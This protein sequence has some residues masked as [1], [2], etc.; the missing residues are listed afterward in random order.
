MP[1]YNITMLLSNAFRPDPRVEREAFALVHAGYQVS[2][3]AWDRQAE[4]PHKEI[5]DG[6]SID[7][8]Q[9]IR[10]GYGSGPRQIF[11]LP[12][13]WDK[14]IQRI[15]SLKPDLVHCHDLDTLYAGIKVK[16]HIGCPV[17]YDAHED[18]PTLMSLYLPWIMLPFLSYFENRLLLSVDHIITASSELSKKFRNQVDLPITTI[19]NFQSLKPY[20]V[21][22][23]MDILKAREDLGLSP[24]DYVVAYIGGFTKN[25]ELLPL[26]D[27][28]KEM[29]NV[30]L[31]LWGD[32]Y[33]RNAVESAI[34]N[35]PNIHYYGWLPAE[36]VPLY[37]SLAD[38]I[39]Y[40]LDSNYPGAVFNAPNTLSNAMAA[41]RP[42]IANPI[43]DL[44]Q[45]IKETNCGLL[46][47]NVTPTNIKMAINQLRDPVLKAQLGLNGKKAAIEKYNSTTT[48]QLLL[49]I[50]NSISQ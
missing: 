25:R 9:S 15:V 48:D 4:F 21:L 46:I 31:L 26:I 39:Y 10:S 44:G 20:T 24:Q 45:I 13:F 2:V 30:K 28:I 19:G 40:C 7:R 3:L 43:G 38:V 27:A 33:Q 36:K 14:A 35:I 32:G 5:R 23:E 49:Q 37:T 17:I 1:K 42:I 47:D 34:I 12:R 41:G 29:P 11:F 18:Y 6:V 22:Q 16:K 8:I 50:Y